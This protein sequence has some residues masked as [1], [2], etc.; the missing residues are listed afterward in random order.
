MS[1]NGIII[2]GAFG[3]LATIASYAILRK[4][5]R[6]VPIERTNTVT[7]EFIDKPIPPGILSSDLRALAKRRS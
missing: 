2:A 4:H 3:I 5:F 1:I 7:D 6:E